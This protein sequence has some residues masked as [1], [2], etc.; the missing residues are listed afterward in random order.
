M[1]SFSN[2]SKSV[3]QQLVL[4]PAFKLCNFLDIKKCISDPEYTHDQMNQW[5]RENPNSKRAHMLFEI[6]SY[7]SDHLKY[8]RKNQYKDLEFENPII[9]AA[10]SNK[11]ADGTN[12][13][14]KP[15]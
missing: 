10:G 14:D 13:F 9:Y 5:I 1:S 15:F 6:L 2:I 7:K 8:T 11:Y 3:I 4:Q 12:Y